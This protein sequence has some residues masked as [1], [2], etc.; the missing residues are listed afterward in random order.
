VGNRTPG[1]FRYSAYFPSKA[2]IP[3]K[4]PHP[5]KSVT[6]SGDLNDLFV[7]YFNS[8]ATSSDMFLI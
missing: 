8:R 3:D 6:H 5:Y 1:N 7:S 4:I 2:C